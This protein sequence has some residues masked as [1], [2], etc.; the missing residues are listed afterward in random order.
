MR[1]FCLGLALLLPGLASANTVCRF[2]TECFGTEACTESGFDMVIS[3]PTGTR[4]I[5]GALM[6]ETD[7]G[8][9]PGFVLKAGQ[10]ERTL[11]FDGETLRMM[12]TLVGDDARLSVH[13]VG[14]LR[15]VSYTGTC[16]AE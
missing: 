2:D 16:E 15:M 9:Y 11:F 13:T 5:T 10:A 8:T 6:A 14:D 3:L 7:G 12:V 1:A 4:S